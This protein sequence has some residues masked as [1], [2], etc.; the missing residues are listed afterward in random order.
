M[1]QGLSAPTRAFQRMS[2]P[3]TRAI[4]RRTLPAKE[5]GRGEYRRKTVEAMDLI[6]AELGS[7][8]YLVGKSFSVADLTAASLLFPLVMPGQYE[9]EY[10]DPVPEGWERLRAEHRGRPAWE[11]VERTYERHRGESAEVAA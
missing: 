2:L 8:G 4:G 7:S 1:Y 5:S 11:Y 3:L 6:E 9:Y 10:P